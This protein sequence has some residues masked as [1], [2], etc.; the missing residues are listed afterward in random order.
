MAAGRDSAG[1]YSG[2][3]NAITTQRSIQTRER[4]RSLKSWTTPRR[5]ITRSQAV[6]E[7][8]GTTPS[9]MLSSRD[10]TAAR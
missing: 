8:G 10:H 3:E 9:N 5:I 7:G 6:A 4:D 2:Y 1:C